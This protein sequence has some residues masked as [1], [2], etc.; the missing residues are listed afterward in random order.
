MCRS[1]SKLV[2]SRAAWLFLAARESGHFLRS[3]C[4]ASGV[5]CVI[6][7]LLGLLIDHW[8]SPLLSVLNICSAGAQLPQLVWLHIGLMPFAH[9]GMVVGVSLCAARHF[10]AVT[11][12]RSVL[13][14][15]AAQALLMMIAELMALLLA[16]NMGGPPVMLTMAVL[17]IVMENALALASKMSGVSLRQYSFA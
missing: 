14:S 11:N 15:A 17:M 6:G 8:R 1:A 10:S 2:N 16:K 7:M 3:T 9:L 5:I 4:R 12:G 13:L